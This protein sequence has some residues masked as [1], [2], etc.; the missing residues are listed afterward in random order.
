[1]GGGGNYRDPNT[2]IH[3]NPGFNVAT[4]ASS[5]GMKE[6]GAASGLG[7]AWMEDYPLQKELN[8]K[9]YSLIQTL[10]YLFSKMCRPFPLCSL[11]INKKYL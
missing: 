2:G 4:W 6:I 3:A 10:Q 1:M 9:R 11:I 5:D 8:Q 7:C